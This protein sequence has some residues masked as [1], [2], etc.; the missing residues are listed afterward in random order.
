MDDRG[1]DGAGCDLAV[2]RREGERAPAFLLVHGL[3]SNARLW[4]E[5]A[6]ELAAAGH[7]TYAVDLRGHGQSPPAPPGYETGAAAAEVAAFCDATGL[8][9]VVA[10]GHSWGGD[11]V[12]RLAAARPDLVAA[13][14]LLDGGWLDL[15]ARFGT[16]EECFAALR[17]PQVRG[18][19]AEQLAVRLRARNPD[20]SAAAV[21]ATVANLR[22]RPDGFLERPL[23]IDAHMVIV[24]GMFDDPPRGYHPAVK[25]PVLA[26][27]AVPADDPTAVPAVLAA[28]TGLAAVII[29]PYP[30]GDHDLHARHPKRVAADLLELAR[31]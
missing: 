16:W 29:K 31:S 2:R 6:A 4:D 24:R 5:V 17:P 15:R 9:G 10:V 23:P 22:Q 7:A 26:L 21:A 20:W 11:V 13:V 27:P 1:G 3:G 14:G 19:R 28:T 30:G 8:H 25:V 18:L 12:V